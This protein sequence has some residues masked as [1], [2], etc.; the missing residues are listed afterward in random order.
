MS[1]NSDETRSLE[2]LFRFC[3]FSSTLLSL[4]FSEPWV[5]DDLNN[6]GSKRAQ[7]E[8]CSQWPNKKT[9]EVCPLIQLSEIL[10]NR[11]LYIIEF[12]LC[13]LYVGWGALIQLWI[14]HSDTLFIFNTI[15]SSGVH[16]WRSGWLWPSA[17]THG[18]IMPSH[19]CNEMHACTRTHTHTYKPLHVQ[20]EEH[21]SL[22]THWTLW[23][24]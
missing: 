16:G 23:A 21:E 6:P 17:H 8:T 9:F 18:L 19:R 5:K 14:T 1:H 22:H 10:Y 7:G 3:Q 20:T 2:W 12:V 13:I 15:S 11:K 24:L 4:F